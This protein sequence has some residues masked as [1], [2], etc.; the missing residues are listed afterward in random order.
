LNDSPTFISALA[1]LAGSRLGVD[2]GALS[3]S[4]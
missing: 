1:N 4:R 2:A 3:Q